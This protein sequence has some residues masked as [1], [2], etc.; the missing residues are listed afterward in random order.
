MFNNESHQFS[1]FMILER[2]PGNNECLVQCAL[3]EVSKPV[4]TSWWGVSVSSHL[5][6]L[7]HYF[8]FRGCIRVSGGV[9]A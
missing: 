8:I 1:L 7:P 6:G 9:K 2:G 3:L 4:I 5:A